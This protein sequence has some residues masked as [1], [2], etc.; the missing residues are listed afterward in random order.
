RLRRARRL[1]GSV[2]ARSAWR[3]IRSLGLLLPQLCS[4]GS[5]NCFHW[6][7]FARGITVAGTSSAGR[8]EETPASLAQMPHQAL[9][10]LARRLAVHS[11]TR[12]DPGE[13]H[14]LPLA[15]GAVSCACLLR[16]DCLLHK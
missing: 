4:V 16:S 8:G 15:L 5:C 7:H 13:R 9:N 1:I 3:A 10:G 2:L 14:L 11:G 6:K 12:A